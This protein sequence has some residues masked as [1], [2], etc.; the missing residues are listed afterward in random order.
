MSFMHVDAFTAATGVFTPALTGTP[1]VPNSAFS[2]NT[3]DGVTARDAECGWLFAT[4]TYSLPASYYVVEQGSV[5]RYESDFGGPN[6]HSL[7]QA[8][9]TWFGNKSY[10]QTYWIRATTESGDAS[11]YGYNLNQWYSLAPTAPG[12]AV[13]FWSWGVTSKFATILEGTIKV[14]IANDNVGTIILATGYY[15]G[16]AQLTAAG[17]GGGGGCFTGNMLVLM[18]DGTEKP[19]KDVVEGDLVVGLAKDNSFVS[20]RVNTVMAPRVCKVY[21]IKLS[22]GK[23]IE[24]TAEHPFKTVTGQWVNIDPEATYQPKLGGHSVKPKVDGKLTCGTRLY[25]FESN[26]EVVKIKDTGRMETVYH[27]ANVGDNQTYF[28][29]GMCVHN[30]LDEQQEKR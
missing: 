23:V 3:A 5:T 6:I 7:Y 14:E 8:D 30:L 13:P 24:T 16:K 20:A 9:I 27:L 19:I 28:V 25:G 12:A 4:N 26:A 1:S 29:E 18:A 17:G 15:K 21:E 10:T 22:N 2:I 11:N